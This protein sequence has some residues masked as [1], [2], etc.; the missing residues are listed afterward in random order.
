M[1]LC[2]W[3]VELKLNEMNQIICKKEGDKLNR[4]EKE[5]LDEE[6]QNKRNKFEQFL[7]LHKK[8][9]DEETV[10]QLLQSHGKVED[11]IK[12]AEMIEKYDTVIVH[13]INK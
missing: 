11:C 4:R 1:L 6:W 2:T 7:N 10:F 13:F 3:I 5:S 12:Y 9:M 8:N